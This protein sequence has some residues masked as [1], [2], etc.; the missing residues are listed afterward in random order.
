M[1]VS[2][3]HSAI[4]VLRLVN[5]SC[6]HGAGKRSLFCN[7]ALL[8]MFGF[9]RDGLAGLLSSSARSPV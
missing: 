1:N 6:V 3:W 8:D 2:L 5:S 9:T 7:K 4:P